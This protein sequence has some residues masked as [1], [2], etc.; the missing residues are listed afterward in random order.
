LHAVAFIILIAILAVLAYR[1]T[2]PE[3]R[4]R[5]LAIAVDFV[6]QLRAAAAEPRPELD[7]LR[8]ALRARTSRALVTPA[9]VLMSTL[10]FGGMLF[11]ATAISD[12]QT[13]VAWGAS[14]GTR[15]SNGE[16][17]RLFTSTFVHTGRCI[18]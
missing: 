18:C 8:D 12:P 15:T 4:A 5:Y 3:E 10:V 9:I 16:W 7:V 11:G 1:V 6:R 2:S 14:L 13:L 17:W